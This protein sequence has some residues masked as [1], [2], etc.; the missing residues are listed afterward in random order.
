MATT[1]RIEV[2][3]MT[4]PRM[5]LVAVRTRDEAGLAEL[6]KHVLKRRS[7]RH[8]VITRYNINAAVDNRIYD[9]LYGY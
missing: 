2:S 7:D 3:Y 5:V 8:E 9:W 1:R 4:N 6:H